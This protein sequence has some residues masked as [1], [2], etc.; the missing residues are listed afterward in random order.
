LE[1]SPTSGEG[2]WQSRAFF[3]QRLLSAIPALAHLNSVHV[4]RL[5]RIWL[6]CG[7]A[8]CR[9]D[10]GAVRIFDAKFGVP[11]DTWCSWA[12]DRDGRMWVR[13]QAHVVVLE[14]GATRFEI[15]DP[16][17]ARLTAEILNVPLVQ[18]SQGHILTSTDV[19]L[20][21][22]QDGWQDY[23]AVNGMPTT[24]ISAILSGRDAQVWLGVPGHGVE[25][26]LGYDHF[27]SWTKAQG[28]GNPV[29]SISPGA[30]HS[31]LLATRAGCSRVDPAAS[32][33]VPCPFA[34]LP[35]GE[36]RVMAQG[37]SA[38]WVGM[39]TGGLFAMPAPP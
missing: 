17:H 36:I 5:G 8:I 15:R 19:G 1:L 14:A 13:G 24:G 4:D 2:Q 7:S 25:R 20:S 18:D 11:D 28:L 29:W 39:T 10:Q 12:L 38:L 35:P 9:V 21:R 22:W 6:G 30:D 23:S 3:P 26:W 32:V 27:E 33:V 31:V 16:P 34:N 37:R